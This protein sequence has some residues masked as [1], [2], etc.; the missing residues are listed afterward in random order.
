MNQ[1]EKLIKVDEYLEFEELDIYRALSKAFDVNV[2]MY[3]NEEPTFAFE[4]NMNST[5]T[6]R[7]LRGNYIDWYEAMVVG[8]KYLYFP[9]GE[10]K[11]L[12]NELVNS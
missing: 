6:K 5:E 2:W 7:D 12:E 9:E 1:N 4:V 8:I 3:A 11:E 10:T